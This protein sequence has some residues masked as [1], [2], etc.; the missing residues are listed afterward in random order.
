MKLAR[1]TKPPGNH[2]D[3]RASGV[4][5]EMAVPGRR[6]PNLDARRLAAI[7][8]I[9]ARF[10]GTP[11]WDAV[12]SLVE[13]ALGC[14][15]TRQALSA[16]PAIKLAFQQRKAGAPVRPGERPVSA[17]AR[18]AAVEKARMRT[19]LAELRRREELLL[20][21]LARWTYNAYANGIPTALL[22]T[23]LGRS[24]AEAAGTQPKPGRRNRATD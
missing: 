14:R 22:E 4:A 16:H 13:A 12:V 19:E 3:V 5:D 21:R 7:V 1:G 8:G 9:I 10:P 11:T 17:R 23:D 15:Y 2:A 6:S 18:A 20:E 24:R